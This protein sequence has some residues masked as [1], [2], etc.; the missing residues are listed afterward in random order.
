MS[1]IKVDKIS[2]ATGANKVS[3]G[4]SGDTI[5]VPSGAT[6]TNLGTAT[7]FGGGM[8]LQVVSN[9]VN[10]R[11]SM[12][13]VI[14]TVT[15]VSNLSCAITPTSASSKIHISMRWTGEISAASQDL[16]FGMRRGATEIGS[17]PRV[18]SRGF[19]MGTIGESGGISGNFDSTLECSYLEY[20]DSPATTSATTYYMTANNV[21]QAGTLYTNRVVSASTNT[22]FDDS[23]SSIIL[24]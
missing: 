8:V 16:M 11:A 5:E 17:C 2:P 9:H 6:F 12:S 4:D 14:N 7:G 1:E 24:T 18:G 10:T 21:Y 19:G 22:G 23:T 13:L 3:L 20:I 15:N